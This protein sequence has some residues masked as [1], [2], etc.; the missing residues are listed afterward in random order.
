MENGWLDEVDFDPEG[1]WLRMGTRR[2]GS[3]PWLMPDSRRE[4]ELAKKDRLLAARHDEVFAVE[5]VAYHASVETL[6]L[7]RSEADGRALPSGIHPLDEA[8]RL[9][10][11]DLCLMAPA[12]GRWNLAGAS[13]CFPTRWRLAEK[14]GRPLAI[15]HRPVIGYGDKLANRVD[16][17]LDAL[18]EQIV[19]RRNWFVLTN[20]ELFQPERRPQEP[21][22]PTENCLAGLYL[23]SERQTLRKLPGSGFVLFTIRIQQE[24]LSVV[25]ASGSWSAA[26]VLFLKGADDELC[27]HRGVSPGQRPLLLDALGAGE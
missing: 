20:P 19:W 15:V 21:V 24:P 18:D 17:L 12:D 14:M 1:A 27:G 25:A 16:G 2:L 5:P 3:R 11:E 10:Q 22:I 8:G 9:V 7:I 13:L 4:L 23:R 26:M 6:E